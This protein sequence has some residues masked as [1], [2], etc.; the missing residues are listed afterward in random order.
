MKL[1]PAINSPQDL[2]RLSPAELSDLCKEIRAYLIDVVTDIGG[3]FASSLGAVE[4]TVALHYL[5]DTPKDKII[6]DVGHQAYVHKILTG[7]AE[8]LRTIRR[9]EGISGFCKR[10]ESEYD[11]FGAGHASTAISAAFGMACARDHRGEDSKVVAVI[12]DGSMTGGLAFEGLN[13]AGASGTDITVILNDNKMSISPNVGALSRY[14]A[15]VI[16]DPVYNRIKADIWNSLG[17]IPPLTGPLRAL[18]KRMDESLKSFLTPGMLFEDLGFKYVG[19]I[20]GHNLEDVLK[21]L[22]KTRQ[23]KEPVL[24]HVLTQK[25]HGHKA[26]EANP[27]K[28]HGIKG[29]PKTPVNPHQPAPAKKPTYSQAFGWTMERLAARDRR[30]I[31]ITAAMAEGTGLADFRKKFPKQFYDVGIA[32]GHGVTFAGGLAAEGL[33]PV[34][35]IYS[36]FLQRAFDHIVHD[37]A[38]QRLPVVF[39]MDRAGIAGE[40]GPTH[41]GCFDIAYLSVIPGM[42]VAAPK[43][44]DELADL[45]FTA[46][47]QDKQPFAIRYPKGDCFKWTE[48]ESYNP[49]P[50]GKWE[51][52]RSGDDVAILAVGSMVAVAQEAAKRL[53]ESNISVEL[54]NAR[55]IKPLDTEMLTEL[56]DDHDRIITVEE[57]CLAGGFGSAVMQSLREHGNN[58]LQMRS[59][60]FEDGFI[61]HGPRGLL[62]DRMGLS[63]PRIEKAV[64]EFLDGQSTAAARRGGVQPLA[65]TANRKHR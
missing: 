28:Y 48:R 8:Q 35:A 37:V 40:D 1:L 52:L 20:D 24:L 3:H 65:A 44:G 12:G 45:L 58:Q 17:K 34:C 64:R 46:L 41:H 5:Y 16:T 62:L 18:G 54:I 22:G 9:F 38:L 10:N 27:T 14:L 32:E 60:G 25:G 50:I 51:R 15:E 29:A 19:P 57:G 4:L 56:A 11:A 30:V 33:R 61:P 43:D 55:F 47:A 36:T 59:L 39:C 6:W 13:N 53:A 42:V 26:A 63:A 31:A 49:L 2:K 7:R 23:L 21:I